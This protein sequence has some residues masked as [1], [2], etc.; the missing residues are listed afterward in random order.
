[1]VPLTKQRAASY[2]VVAKG[3]N[4]IEVSEE[5]KV[6]KGEDRASLYIFIK[7]EEWKAAIGNFSS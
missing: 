5:R 6:F 3:Q 2:Y 4:F 1:M 7:R